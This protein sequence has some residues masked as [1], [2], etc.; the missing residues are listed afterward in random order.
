[1][2]K[3]YPLTRESMCLWRM[4]EIP[5]SV[6]RGQVLKVPDDVK[7][8]ASPAETALQGEPSPSGQHGFD[9]PGIAGLVAC[10]FGHGDEAVED[11]VLDPFVLETERRME[12]GGKV[13]PARPSTA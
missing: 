12:L 11:L 6:R 9:R 1:M 13:D 8:P 2:E 4:R 5:G 7:P 10:C 3:A